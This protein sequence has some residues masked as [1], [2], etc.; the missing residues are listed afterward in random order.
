[1]DPSLGFNDAVYALALQADGRLLAGGDFTMANGLARQRIAR[2]NTDGSL[3]QT[4]S[5][6][7]PLRGPTTRC[8]LSSVKPTG[9]SSRR[10]VHEP[11]QR[12]P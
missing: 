12:A 6:T 11:Q 7:S 1:M 9:V 4:F 10:R 5:S 8:W 3:D 2:L